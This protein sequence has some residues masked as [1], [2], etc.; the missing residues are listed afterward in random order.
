M[1]RP[2]PLVNSQTLANH[3]GQIVR[4]VGKVHKLTGNVLLVQASD[5]GF[6]EVYLNPESNVSGSVYVEIT[7]KVSESGESMRELLSINFGENLDLKLV[8]EVVQLVPKFP[9]IF[10]SKD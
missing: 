4:L 8:E 2:V 9:E 3:R 6:V 7:G 1:D 10:S 5:Q